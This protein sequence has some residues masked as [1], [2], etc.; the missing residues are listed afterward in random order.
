MDPLQSNCPSTKKRK[1][2]D[3]NKTQEEKRRKWEAKQAKNIQQ[4]ETESTRARW[5][6]E[7]ATFASWVSEQDAI[8]AGKREPNFL[9]LHELLL[10]YEDIQ[11]T[12]KRPPSE[13]TLNDGQL[14]IAEGTETV[15]LLIQQTI[16]ERQNGLKPVSLKSIF[17]KPSLLFDEPV[18]LLQD[19][20]NV[21]Q[22]RS[23]NCPG[24]HVL[25]GPEAVLSK[26]AG[27]QVSRGAMA[28]GVVPKD[29]D[30]AWLDGLIG[31]HMSAHGTKKLRFLALDGICDTA[32][33]GS[34]VRCASAFGIDAV[35]L[36]TDCCDAWYRRS[37]RVSMGHIFKVPVVRVENLAKLLETWKARYPALRSFAAVIDTDLL[38]NRHECVE[39]SWC[40]VMGNEGNGIS[41]PVA[42]A[43]TQRIRI[44]IE[45]GVDSLSVP[46][47]CG[48]LLHG[49]RERETS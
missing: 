30:E 36:S 49:L 20:Q 2:A 28:C 16:Q 46:I 24:F 27:F 22:Y 39:S 23:D 12:R 17:V 41:K 48:I 7:N 31:L 8:A 42:D 19:V 37:V 15:R 1:L 25:V 45:R 10:P 34:M 3:G 11:D 21:I 44:E 43:C 33:M 5:F 13:C 4:S 29:C 9:P 14:F 35:I 38:L 47:A 6:K 18:N 26:V 40:C 32:N